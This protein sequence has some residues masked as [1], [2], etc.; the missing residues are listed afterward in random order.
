MK[1]ATMK[2]VEA[3]LRAHMKIVLREYK[4]AERKWLKPE[5][6]VTADE[7]EMLRYEAH[8]EKLERIVGVK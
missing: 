6:P 3:K 5:E 7:K 1:T 4:A 2:A 8:L